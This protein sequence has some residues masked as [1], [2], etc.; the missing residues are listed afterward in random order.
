MNRVLVSHKREVRTDEQL[1]GSAIEQFM[2]LLGP[3]PD[4][5]LG[6]DETETE[7]RLEELWPDFFE[8]FKMNGFS[9]KQLQ[10]ENKLWYVDLPHILDTDRPADFSNEEH[11]AF[12]HF[13][14][15]CTLKWDPKD[16]MTASQLLKHEWI[17]KFCQ[18]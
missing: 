4:G 11:E 5:Y 6:K 3:I 10:E 8:R 14:V 1:R 18:G 13:I 12:S 7:D 2:L 9:T 15:N 17:T 16:R